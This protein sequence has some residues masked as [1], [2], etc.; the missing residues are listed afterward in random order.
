MKTES[1]T[2]LRH[3]IQTSYPTSVEEFDSFGTT[4]DC[5]KN[6][7]RFI[8]YS[9][10]AKDI[11]EAFAG[12]IAEKTGVARKRLP[13]KGGGKD[14]SGNPKTTL[15]L[16]EAYFLRVCKEKGLNAD[17]EPFADLAVRLSVG[18]DTEVKFALPTEERI[19][20]V[21]TLPVEFKDAAT[22][23]VRAGT[24]EQNR[25]VLADTS[26]GNYYGRDIGVQPKDEEE[27]VNVLG[28]AIRSYQLNKQKA[29]SQQWK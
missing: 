25:K 12:L 9:K 16:P 13:V 18:G 20:V 10:T 3:K 19:T 11:T 7:V 4:G 28:N 23:I 17:K 15:E 8:R 29:E 6:G 1:S 26:N 2:S 21:K 14:R 5:L 27:A 24:W 22:R